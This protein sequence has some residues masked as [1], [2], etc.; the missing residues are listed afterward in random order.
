MTLAEFREKHWDD[1]W[2]A[3]DEDAYEAAHSEVEAMTD[4][5]AI[6][7]VKDKCSR[8]AALMLFLDGTTKSRSMG[9]DMSRD[10]F[11]TYV[12]VFDALPERFAGNISRDYLLYLL[13]EGDYHSEP[14]TFTEDILGH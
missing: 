3:D 1:D 13:E 12:D 8:T 6:R 4:K 7:V 5:D 14:D 10:D 9:L 2:C 11:D